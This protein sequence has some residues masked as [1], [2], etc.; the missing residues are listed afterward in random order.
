MILYHSKNTRSVGTLVLLEELG[1]KYELK[2]LDIR[3]GK[4]ELQNIWQ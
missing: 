3:A 4:I 2:K 1:A